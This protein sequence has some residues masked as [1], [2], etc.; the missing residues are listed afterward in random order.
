MIDR[1]SLNIIVNFSL[2]ISSSISFSLV[3]ISK[4]ITSDFFF[5]N[6]LVSAPAPGPISIIRSS[7]VGLIESAI[8][9]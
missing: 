8:F 1:K 9:L 3:S 7:S 2:F 6:S 5:T 4:Q